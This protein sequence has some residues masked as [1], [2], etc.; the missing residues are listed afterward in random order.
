[1]AVTKKITVARKRKVAAKKGSLVLVLAK[2]V[3]ALVLSFAVMAPQALMP[4]AALAETVPAANPVLSQ[5]CGLDIVLVLDNS[6]SIGENEMDQM[7]TAMIGFVN[8]F[9]GTPTQFSVT[10]FGTTA[11]V[12]QNFTTDISAVNNAINNIPLEGGFTNWQDALVKA[13]S[14]FD[15]RPTVPNLIV[16]ASDGDP[17]HWGVPAQ[18]YAPDASLEK[19]IIEANSIKN[20]GTIII[21]LGIGAEVKQQNMVAISSAD[22]YYPVNNFDALAQVLRDLAQGLCGGTITVN[23]FVGEIENW[24]PAGAGWE[25]NVGGNAGKLTDANGQTEAVSLLNGTYSVV[26]TPQAGYELVNAECHTNNNGQTSLGALD[27]QNYQITDINITADDIVSCSFYNRIL[28]DPVYGCTDPEATNYNPLA[29][30]DNGSCRYPIIPECG[31]DILENGEECDDGN[32]ENGDGCSMNCTIEIAKIAGVCGPAAKVYPYVYEAEYYQE[33]RC[34]AGTIGLQ[35]IAFPDPGQTVNWTCYGE[36]GGAD[37]SCS[38]SRDLAPEPDPVLGCTDQSATNYNSDATEDDGSCRYPQ[39]S[40]GGSSSGSSSGQ[41]MPG[42]GPAA[43]GIA[44]QVAGAEIDLD[45]IANQI[46]QIRQKVRDIAAQVMDK[47]KGVLGAATEVSTGV[48]DV[49][50]DNDDNSG[51]S[52]FAGGS[53]SD[54]S[55]WFARLR[56]Q[57]CR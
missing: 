50:S 56:A 47:T 1:M 45:D 39:P 19:A 37:I 12:L 36:N 41:Y 22:A 48:C 26:E 46:S 9:D 30:E 51:S 53:S 55:S 54:G 43:G 49:D 3:C 8:S 7:K 20:S 32:V 6:T 44:P 18:G 38:A 52:W 35:M 28:T 29:T 25:F 34:S 5:S 14:T 4:L 24:T 11:E 2:K 40:S 17:N 10:K 31:N 33:D 27:L 15:P 23:K 16:F 13:Q 42:Y 57:F 21:T